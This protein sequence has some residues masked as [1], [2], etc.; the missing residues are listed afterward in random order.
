LYQTVLPIRPAQDG[1]VGSPVSVVATIV[2]WLFVYGGDAVRAFRKLSFTGAVPKTMLRVR[3][4]VA[5]LRVTLPTCM[6]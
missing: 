4:A 2:L 3:L 6:R 5:G 1:A